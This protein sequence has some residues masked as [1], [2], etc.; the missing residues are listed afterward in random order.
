VLVGA[1]VLAG[2]IHPSGEVDEY[3]L[4]WHVCFWDLWFLL[5]GVALGIAVRAAR[6]A[7][8]SSAR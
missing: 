6:R 3:A 7:P 5:W 4:R 2:V 8:L 1:L